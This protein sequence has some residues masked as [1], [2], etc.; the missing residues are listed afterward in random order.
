MRDAKYSVGSEVE[1]DPPGDLDDQGIWHVE[2][3][4]WDSRSRE[5]M[6]EISR[7]DD[8]FVTNTVRE[9]ELKPY[10]E[11]PMRKPI[12]TEAKRRSLRSLLSES[13]LN[14]DD[15][16]APAGPPTKQ[17]GDDSLDNQVDRYFAEYE[18]SSKS[19]Q[20]EGRDFR[21]T[22]RRLLSEAGDDDTASDG[23][24][25]GAGDDATPAPAAPQKGNIDQIDVEEFANN[26]ARL[27]ENYDNLLEVR[28][29]LVR[30][31]INFIS[32]NYDQTTV[33]SLENTLRDKH[34]M[35]AGETK[36]EVDDDMFT[37]PRADR[38]GPGGAGS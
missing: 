9:S 22:I 36:Q 3:T 7:D 29:T 32:K 27:V 17:Q 10:E 16:P 20:H 12:R 6:Y 8:P 21:M 4:M 35:A 13:Y 1:I 38:A 5:Y 34:G 24:D 11:K 31:A 15:A 14:E 2:G 33:S 25:A 23:P 30:R 26:V 28:S 37:A 19:A 18:S